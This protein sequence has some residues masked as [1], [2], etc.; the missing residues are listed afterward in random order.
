M[1]ITKQYVVFG[2]TEEEVFKPLCQIRDEFDYAGWRISLNDRHPFTRFTV[3]NNNVK[4]G[5]YSCVAGISRE[6]SWDNCWISSRVSAKE[7][8]SIIM[9]LSISDTPEIHF[10]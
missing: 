6:I 7:V 9:P 5:V 10:F 2:K 3:T 8:K 4:I 1:L